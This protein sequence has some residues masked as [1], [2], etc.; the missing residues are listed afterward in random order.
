MKA[1]GRLRHCFFGDY[2]AVVALDYGS[3]ENSLAALPTLGE[4]WK[5]GKNVACLV[6]QGDSKALEALKEKLKA[7]S[8]AIDPCGWKHCKGQCKGAEIDS[9]AH[10]V[11]VGPAF[12]V[13][14]LPG[15]P[16]EQGVLFT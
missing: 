2:S 10:S 7:Y 1:K 4:G 12:T 15:V 3:Q 16:K 14:I 9:L 13:D 11:D 8:L 5:P 6:W